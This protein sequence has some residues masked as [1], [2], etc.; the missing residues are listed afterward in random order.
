M[1]E[2]RNISKIAIYQNSSPAISKTISLKPPIKYSPNLIR[3]YKNEFYV[4]KINPK[5][6]NYFKKIFCWIIVGSYTWRL[7][8]SQKCFY[9]NKLYLTLKSNEVIFW[10]RFSAIQMKL[11]HSWLILKLGG[12]WRIIYMKSF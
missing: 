4:N 9:P 5:W 8:S 3:I 6:P 1:N 7:K 11:C 2:N 10:A 12:R